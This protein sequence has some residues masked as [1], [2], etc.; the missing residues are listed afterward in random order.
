MENSKPDFPDVVL[1]RATVQKRV[2]SMRINGP[3]C[4]ISIDTFDDMLS[5]IAFVL[6]NSSYAR[7][8]FMRGCIVLPDRLMI[9]FHFSARRTEMDAILQEPENVRDI[10]DCQNPF[11]RMPLVIGPIGPDNFI[12]EI[13]RL[14]FPYLTPCDIR[15]GIPNGIRGMND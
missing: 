2:C 3:A 9:Y 15:K 5:K 8:E 12:G 14:C 7:Y 10:L 4:P 1:S 11:Q 13:A 6:L